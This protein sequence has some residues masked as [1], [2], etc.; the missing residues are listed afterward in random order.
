MKIRIVVAAALLCLSGGFFTASSAENGNGNGDEGQSDLARISPY[1]SIAGAYNWRNTAAGDESG[2]VNGRIG[3]R[4][5]ERLAV[6]FEGDWQGK[7]PQSYT[8]GGNLKGYWMKGRIQPFMLV[9]GSYWDLDKGHTGPG[10]RAGGGVDGYVNDHIYLTTGVEYVWGVGDMD[11]FN[12]ATLYL[13][14]GF[15]L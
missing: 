13:G 11:R 4:V 14:V 6:E 2:G 5:W 9:G 7:R 10:V 1:A 8:L 12:Y 15:R 3:M